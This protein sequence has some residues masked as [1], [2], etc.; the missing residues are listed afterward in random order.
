MLWSAHSC[1]HIQKV[2]MVAIL[3]SVLRSKDWR[4][5]FPRAEETISL[6]ATDLLI[7]SGLVREKAEGNCFCTLQS[8]AHHN[9]LP[10]IILRDSY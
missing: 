3:A 8:K 7:A 6:I 1:N 10:T 2:V 5:S 9:G 4:T